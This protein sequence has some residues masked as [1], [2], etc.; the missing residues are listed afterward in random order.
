MCLA[1]KVSLEW[2]FLLGFLG[3]YRDLLGFSRMVST[4]FRMVFWRV[5]GF[6]NFDGFLC[7]EA[8]F[9]GL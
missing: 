4:C 7:F 8:Y 1:S 5:P 6:A 2:Y 9:L 3:V